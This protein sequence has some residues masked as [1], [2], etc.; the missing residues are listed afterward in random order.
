MIS[1]F[2]SSSGN[3]SV[4]AN[5]LVNPTL[6]SSADSA[7]FGGPGGT[8]FLRTVHGAFL[9]GVPSRCLQV[10]Y[11][12]VS[13]VWSEL[14]GAG[15]GGGRMLSVSAHSREESKQRVQDI[16]GLEHDW[17]GYGG[18]PPSRSVCEQ[19]KKF[20]DL[21]GNDFPRLE[22]PD[23]SP[24]SNGTIVLSWDAKIGEA[25][26]E[27]GDERFSAYVRRQKDFI[28]I[29]GELSAL[30]ENELRLIWETLYQ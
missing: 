4:E 24:T 13:S 25:C 22:S 26:V 10:A 12:D 5:G 3:L 16:A 20:I 9:Q 8:P 23:I 15:V 7:S 17:D 29:V 18:Y 2:A 28:P 21:L 19:A 6:I 14:S 27:V 30:G 1:C 11:S